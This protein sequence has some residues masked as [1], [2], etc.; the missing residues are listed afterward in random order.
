MIINKSGV[1][2]I[3]LTFTC[4]SVENPLD[5]Q[6]PWWQTHPLRIYH[7]NMK[8]I[9]SKDFD[10]KKFIADC[11]ELHAEAVVFSTRAVYAFY[12]TK[13]NVQQKSTLM[14]NRDLLAEVIKEAGANNIK[15]IARLDFTNAPR[16]YFGQHPD[17][18][19]LD[20]GGKPRSSPYDH[21]DRFYQTNLLGGYQNEDFAIPVFN[22]LLSNYHLNGFHLNGAGWR[23]T[24]YDGS[25]IKKY[26]IPTDSKQLKPWREKMFSLQLQRYHSLMLEKKSNDILFMGETNSI[27]TA[28]WALS[29]GYNPELMAK[30]FTNILSTSGEPEGN[31]LYRFRWWVSLTAD[32]LHSSNAPGLPIINLKTNNNGSQLTMKP[33]LEYQF[34]AYQALAHNAGLKTPTMGLLSNMPDVRTKS[35]I[36]EIFQ[37]MEQQEQYMTNAE[38]IAPVGLIWPSASGILETGEV[39][40]FE[41]DL[42]N[43]M[44]GLY[45]TLVYK[46][47]L[48]R[49]LNSNNITSGN[50]SGLKVLV[51]PDI[52][53]L[54]SKTTKI[55]I[56]FIENGGRLVVI[57]HPDI[58]NSFLPFP[59]EIKNKIGGIWTN[60]ALE[61]KYAIPQKKLMSLADN[62]LGTLKYEGLFRK[63]TPDKNAEIL[64]TDSPNPDID[65]FPEESVNL[66]EGKNPILFT[67]KLGK[68]EFVYFGGSLG[69]IIWKEDFPDLH[70]ILEKIIYPDNKSQWLLTDAPSTVNIT[71]FKILEGFVIHMV[72][73]TGSIPLNGVVPIHNIRISVKEK[74]VKEI[75]LCSPGKIPENLIFSSKGEMLEINVPGLDAYT[76]IIIL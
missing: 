66:E 70:T 29:R 5:A 46:H 58:S 54:N 57:D 37:F 47:I 20:P 22:E 19:H 64:L 31:L 67:Q 41:D 39:K 15:V 24:E 12:D 3:L 63:V 75:K 44:Y 10:V 28:G 14:G 38:Q 9:E 4:F 35:M 72:N 27:E 50:I 74:T 13:I 18:F 65:N 23:G 56:D 42:R 53:L 25:L 62:N 76:Q 34:Y 71:G 45:S 7:P 51:L 26:N 36:K 61:S 73:G 21:S 8:E 2:F 1:L 32:W 69:E 17:W 49:L 60:E 68:G 33:V 16:R 40:N 59:E 43:Q 30:G 55:V 52:E 48:F 6:K 11:K